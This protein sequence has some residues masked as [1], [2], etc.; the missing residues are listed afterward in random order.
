[1]KIDF[2]KNFLKQK[3]GQNY[4]KKLKLTISTVD[5]FIG[6]HDQTILYIRQVMK[7]LFDITE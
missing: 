1:M 3:E 7:S 5:E 4:M 6:K 2:E